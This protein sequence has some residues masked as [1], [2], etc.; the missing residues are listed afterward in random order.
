[1]A[2]YDKGRKKVLKFIGRNGICEW[3]ITLSIAITYY[4]F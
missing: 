2:I 3:D 4:K 1:M